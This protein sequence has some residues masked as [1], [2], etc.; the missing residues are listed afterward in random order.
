MS[1]PKNTESKAVN[2]T[3]EA[4]ETTSYLEL[5]LPPSEG[6][7]REAFD[8]M[9]PIVT[10]VHAFNGHLRELRDLAPQRVEE[11]VMRTPAGVPLLESATDI[12][13]EEI[14]NNF[15]VRWALANGTE[16]V[17]MKLEDSQ[18]VTL[19]IP[20]KLTHEEVLGIREGTFTPKK[21]RF[22]TDI[23]DMEAYQRAIAVFPDFFVPLTE[24][25]SRFASEAAYNQKT[26]FKTT[27]RKEYE[28]PLY[29]AWQ[30]IAPLVDVND[31]SYKNFIKAGGLIDW[32]MKS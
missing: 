21:I 30:V 26:S 6:H 2:S 4:I 32:Y 10:N 22:G 15:P 16:P 28:E 27:L 24:S 1:N 20:V 12:L 23:T 3:P 19:K 29:V 31:Q 9:M 14:T 17:A 8:K 7:L 18:E 5:P 13:D 11:L 25:V